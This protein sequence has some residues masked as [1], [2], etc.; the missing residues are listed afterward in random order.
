MIGLAQI[1]GLLSFLFVLNEADSIRLKLLALFV[2]CQAASAFIILAIQF[3]K[4]RESV[5]TKNFFF[6]LAIYFFIIFV[7]YKGSTG[8]SFLIE[9]TII[10][11]FF[12]SVTIELITTSLKKYNLLLLFKILQ[13]ISL[14]LVVIIPS[15]I[16]FFYLF[17]FLFFGLFFNLRKI[18]NESQFQFNDLEDWFNN[19]I[20]QL[21]FIIYPFFD[22]LLSSRIDISLYGNYLFYGKIFIGIGN[23]LFSFWMFKLIKG[24]ILNVKKI[25]F[26]I[27]AI[28]FLS[29]LFSL[30]FT[31]LFFQV[32]CLSLLINLSSLYIRSYIEVCKMPHLIISLL[33]VLIYFLGLVFLPSYFFSSSYNYFIVLMIISFSIS[34]IY[35]WLTKKI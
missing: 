32:I 30:I 10:S 4:N 18:V 16:L 3:S 5:I 25:P 11:V 15:V 22:P 28:V 27:L 1:L 24:E 2:A 20:M 23:F 21:P 35:V 31:Q 7:I 13:S 29:F 26:F 8:S 17:Q 9:F 14:P 19:L 34:P 6:F 33:S 12:I